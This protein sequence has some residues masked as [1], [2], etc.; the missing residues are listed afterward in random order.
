MR[1]KKKIALPISFLKE[2][3]EE[4]TN[5]ARS[6]SVLEKDSQVT[7]RKRLVAAITLSSTLGRK[8]EKEVKKDVP[9][10][11]QQ[12]R[13]QFKTEVGRAVGGISKKEKKGECPLSR[14]KKKERGAS[15]FRKKGARASCNFLERKEKKGLNLSAR[16]F[17]RGREKKE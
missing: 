17:K 14:R 16:T 9:E 12:L 1:K 13:L 4:G 3:K 2:E 8:G 10:S 6:I 11:S 5:D 7:Y 15:Q